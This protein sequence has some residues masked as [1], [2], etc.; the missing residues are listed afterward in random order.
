MSGNKI[1]LIKT[2]RYKVF[3]FFIACNIISTSLAQSEWEQLFYD[4]F[5]DGTADDWE[6]KGLETNSYWE[7][8]NDND[9]YV[10]KGQG[11]NWAN[12]V[13]KF[14]WDDY[15]FRC[16]VKII[17]G[18]I[19]INYRVNDIARYFIAFNSG[20]ITL[21][22]HDW[23]NPAINL[24]SYS[25]NF[26]IDRW[27]IINIVGI[28]GN[29][30]VFVDDQLKIDYTD[31]EPVKGGS[32]AF[33]VNP[34]SVFYVDNIEVIGEPEPKPPTG[35][36]WHRT[37]GPNGGLG[38]DIRIHPNDKKIMFV[39]DNPSGVNK[40]TDEG[41]TWQQ[42]NEGI[43]TD[44]DR[45]GNGAPIFSLT[46][47]PSNPDI[48]WS[49]TQNFNGLYK[50][51][52][53]G[54]TWISKNQGIT[55]GDE[56]SFRGFAVHPNNSNVVLAA[57]EVKTQ[58]PAQVAVG[59][60]SKGKIY[61]TI[62][63]GDNWYPVW[64]GDNL[65]RVLIFDYMNPDILYCSTGIF[66]VE[67]LNTDVSN[68]SPGGEGILKS[69]DRG[70][71]WFSINSG[72]KNLYIGFLE[73]HPQNPKILYAAAGNPAI[74]EPPLNIKGGLYKTINGGETWTEILS[75]PVYFS[76]V[77]ISKSDPETVYA[78]TDYAFYRSTDG[79]K[80]WNKFN[81]Q[82]ADYNYGPPG[83]TAGVPISAVVDPDNSNIVY[84]NSYQGGNFKSTD[85]GITW[86]NA[87]K[88]YSGADLRDIAVDKINSAEVHTVGRTGPFKSSNGGNDWEGL[89]YGPATG[90]QDWYKLI[91]NPA[92]HN[93][94][95]MS[96]E[97]KGNI[98][99]STDGGLNWRI[100]FI[101]PEV[102]Q[103]E[104][105]KRHGFKALVYSL[106][107]P[108]IIYGGMR[109]TVSGGHLEPSYGPSFGIYK[110][111]DGGETWVEKNSGLENSYKSINVIV[112]HP[113]NSQIAY[114]GTLLD[115]IYKTT[116]GG[117]NWIRVS[118]GLGFTDVR[119]LAIDPVKTEIIY[120]GS[121]DGKGIAKSIDGGLS[122]QETNNGLKIVC[123]SY[124][125]PIG[126]TTIG[127][128]LTK[129]KSIF[130]TYN[131]FNIIPWTK[132]FDIIIDP[133]NHERVYAAD[134]YSGVCVSE[135][136]GNSWWQI[137]EGLSI[138]TV[139]CLAISSDGEVLY[140]GT[141]G[142][143]VHRLVLGTN[144]VPQILSTIPD[145]SDT[146]VISYGDSLSFNVTAFD[147]D[148]DTLTYQ[149]MFDGVLDVNSIGTDYLLRTKNKNIGN[150]SLS[151]YISDTDTTVSVSW[152]ISIT[153]PT[154][155]DSGK[156]S[157]TA[158][159]FYLGQ[160]Y[161]NPF[162]P[163][164]TITFTIPKPE[165]VT[166]KLFNVLGE[167]VATIVSEKLNTA[168]YTKEWNAAG[169]PSG[170]YFYRI[171][172]GEFVETKKLLLLR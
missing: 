64:E 11:Q 27:Y 150:H 106:S 22:K 171:R 39:T 93:I 79:G 1:N 97:S 4:D 104:L 14:L 23:I 55:E 61:K 59:V 35:Y 15:S 76:V 71:T 147:L 34:S 128:D 52:D 114:A 121:G 100:V 21:F 115:G 141:S 142:G 57:A 7:V 18:G 111:T 5:E 30:K 103:Q 167:E 72:I 56:I 160:N 139:T 43:N 98:L 126:L 38:Y 46:V 54:E 94:L 149:W 50:S 78:G 87:S 133:K 60:K 164:T 44:P 170:V 113:T 49:G 101:H 108:D 28:G 42:K 6:L 62:D 29:I 63:G 136:G 36:V 83:M 92:N 148:N 145:F 99:K 58:I 51:T 124:L 159:V 16:E 102:H 80:T 3:F 158:T 75:E 81:N 125:S 96:Q 130:N 84:I 137:N 143:G 13:K 47:D 118:S 45:F 117:D 153:T 17:Y 154:H 26:S 161:P 105:D 40:S 91:V 134:L 69:T 88:G 95:L 127:Y 163:S 68:N 89:S 172:A 82:P 140:A 155:V 166:L 24:I 67:A 129:P 131:N 122:W 132:I 107:N 65:A 151:A 112:V 25:E 110:S 157:S 123:P 2:F 146:V 156:F 37:G 138:K 109:K 119:S 85:G 20:S 73:M 33:E 152:M 53:G 169:F 10:L 135:D 48:V 8:Y 66:D 32:I 144:K 162:N 19:H 9:N 116:N 12:P 90:P 31:S 74:F 168:T 86:I 120:A 165:F 70:E 41:K 77:T